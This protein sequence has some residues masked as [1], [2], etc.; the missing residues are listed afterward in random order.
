M[1]VATFKDA[2]EEGED[3]KDLLFQ[4]LFLLMKVA[5]VIQRLNQLKALLGFRTFSF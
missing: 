5:T 4:N 3:F 1:K 2:I